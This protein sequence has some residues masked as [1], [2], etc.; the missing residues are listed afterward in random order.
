MI[1]AGLLRGCRLGTLSY[2][3]PPVGCGTNQPDVETVDAVACTAHSQHPIAIVTTVVDL[4]PRSFCAAAALREFL[5]DFVGHL[6]LLAC[7]Q[8]GRIPAYISDMATFFLSLRAGF[9]RD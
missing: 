9:S 6:G 2:L 5:C 8:A 1:D 7:Y 3:P 4:D